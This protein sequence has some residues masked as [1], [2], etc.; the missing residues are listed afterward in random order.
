MRKNDRI[1]KTLSLNAKNKLKFS[2]KKNKRKK[3]TNA[4]EDKCIYFC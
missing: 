2:L 4:A 3:L 1:N